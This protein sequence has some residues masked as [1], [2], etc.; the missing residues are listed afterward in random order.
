MIDKTCRHSSY[1]V[2]DECRCDAYRHMT[3]ADRIRNMTDEGLAEWMC[4]E[5]RKIPWG[6]SDNEEDIESG[7][8]R[9]QVCIICANVWLKEEVKE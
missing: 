9:P 3:N 7:K 5:Y 6:R 4:T 8:C 1:C 2:G